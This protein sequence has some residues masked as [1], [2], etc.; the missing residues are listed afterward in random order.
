MT[1]TSARRNA[2]ESPLLRLPA[3]IRNKIWQFTLGYHRIMIYYQFANIYGI[4]RRAIQLAHS[5]YAGDPTTEGSIVQP[6]FALPIVC[7]Q[8]YVEAFAM[9]YSLNTFNFSHRSTLDHFIRNRALGQRRLVASIVVPCDYF[10]LYRSDR[11]KRFRQTFPN[12]KHVRVLVDSNRLGWNLFLEPDREQFLNT[13]IKDFILS[14][15]GDGLEVDF[16]VDFHGI[17]V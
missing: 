4:G 3:E 7:R 13:E 11:R 12:L 5:V 9:V 16:V 15:E 6:G 2:T 10:R 1:H 14:K 8:T 17:S